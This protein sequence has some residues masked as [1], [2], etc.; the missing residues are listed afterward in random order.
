MSD[1]SEHAPHSADTQMN[2]QPRVTRTIVMPADAPQPS[3][4]AASTRTI[5]MPENTKTSP[6]DNNDKTSPQQEEN[7]EDTRPVKKR[8]AR[9]THLTSWLSL[10]IS[11]DTKANQDFQKLDTQSVDSKINVSEDFAKEHFE[12]LDKSFTIQDEIARGGQGVISKG[13]DRHCSRAV[14][15][16]T[17]HQNLADNTSARNLF[18]TEAKITAQLEHPSIIPIYGIFGDADNGLHLAMKMVKGKSFADYLDYTVEHYRKYTPRQIRRLE[19]D[20]L[21]KRLAYFL[22]VVEAIAYVHHNKIIHKDLKPENIMIG[23]FGE[24]YVMDW[25]IAEK[26]APGGNHPDKISGTLAYIAPEVINRKTYDTRSD[27]YLLGLILFELV[28][29]KPAYTYQEDDM[30]EAVRIA[31][32]AD[33]A[34]PVHLFGCHVDTDLYYILNR[35]L[36]FNPEDRYQKAEQLGND[37]RA[38]LQHDVVSASPHQ[39]IARICKFTVNHLPLFFG[40]VALLIILFGGMSLH[41]AYQNIHESKVALQRK[42]LLSFHT[43]SSLRSANSIEAIFNRLANSVH[44]LAL[45]ATTRL[46]TTPLPPDNTVPTAFRTLTAPP[47][48]L[49]TAPTYHDQNIAFSSFVFKEADLD[50][51]NDN[52]HIMQILAPMKSVFQ[53]LVFASLRADANTIDMSDEELIDYGTQVKRPLLFLA[54]VGFNTGLH[55]AYPYNQ[56][57]PDTY[58]PRKR[59]WFINAKNLERGQVATP[60]PYADKG[61]SH[62]LLL[63]FSTPL[64]RA[65]GTLIGVA[66]ADISLEQARQL[67]RNQRNSIQKISVSMLV[68]HKG[69]ILVSSNTA[70]SSQNATGKLP[71][72]PDLKAFSRISQLNTGVVFNTYNNLEYVYVCKHIDILNVFYIERI[73]FTKLLW[74]NQPN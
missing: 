2:D 70:D 42:N 5:V 73:N 1:T 40:F 22:N 38:Y 17:L 19:P 9:L 18:L 35:A 24:T 53:N 68:D 30:K 10:L 28:F 55:I 15:I 25:G 52:R 45:E 58:D 26:V 33:I 11:P 36:A 44:D 69:Q 8:S 67:L 16:K 59:T 51:T 48:D 64:K 72:F 60:V 37:I 34:P 14:A 32:N 43:N 4:H 39:F 56:G 57:Y 66:G 3:P 74:N 13:F 21:K 63:S 41:I 46:E 49:L 12:D 7:L 6:P 47:D 50:K 31:K 20:N 23:P 65:D 62:E 71:L 61:A 29:L 27:I 54:Y